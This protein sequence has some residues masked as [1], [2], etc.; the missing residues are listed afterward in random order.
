MKLKNPLEPKALRVFAFWG[1]REHLLT[2]RGMWGHGGERLLLPWKMPQ[3]ILYGPN[4]R[5]YA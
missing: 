2:S 3:E 1:I 4:R 5:C